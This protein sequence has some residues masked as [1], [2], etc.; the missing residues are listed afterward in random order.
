MLDMPKKHLDKFPVIK[1]NIEQA[2]QFNKDNIK[3]F[4]EFMRFIFDTSLTDEDVA[5]LV[6]R[7]MPAI[8]F[9]IVESVIS[10]LRGE[11]LT[12]QPSVEVRAAD[13]VP[14]AQLND[15]LIQKIDFVEAHLR[16]I[17]SDAS[18]DMFGNAIYTDL[19]GGGFSA[20]I[21]G[22]K[23]IHKKSFEQTIYVRRCFDP[24]LCGFDPLARESHKGDGGFVFEIFPM[25]EQQ[26]I[27]TFGKDKIEGMSFI[28]QN[29]LDSFDW[30]YTNGVEK[31]ALIC[32]YYEKQEKAATLYELSDGQTFYKKEY[33][34]FMEDWHSQVR[35]EQAPVIV[36]TRQTTI[37]KIV[38]YRV[39]ETGIL[40]EDITDYEYLPIVFF[41]GNTVNINKNGIRKK[42][43]RPYVYHAKG[44]QK[45]KNL[46]GQ[47]MGN[48]LENT[49]Q[50]KII[51]AVESI[52][53]SQLA[54][55]KNM[56]KADTFLYNHF[57]Q[58]NNFDVTLPPPREV[59]RTQ[60]PPQIAETFAMA[61]TAIQVILGNHDPAGSVSSGALSGVAYA[62]GAI[63][64][65]TAAK[66]FEAGYMAGL[67][68]IGQI[69]LDLLPKYCK[70]PRSLPV[71]NSNGERAYKVVNDENSLKLDYDPASLQIKIEA[72]VNFAIQKEMALQT[73]VSLSQSMKGFGQF[74]EEVGLQ[75][76]LDNIDI[77]GIDG[78]KEKAEKYEQQQA[79][80]K[81]QGM[82]VQQQQM[83]MQ[84]QKQ[85]MEMAL[86]QKQLQAPTS[87][88]I[89]VM[90]LQEQSKV[91]AANL[92]VKERDS[93]TKFIETMSKIRNADT[94]S[95]LKKAEIDAENTRTAVESMLNVSKHLNEVKNAEKQSESQN[96]KTS[97]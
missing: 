64:S 77:R 1:R 14:L 48:E 96:T 9:N 97:T 5:A 33:E 31:V 22:T 13:G 37:P 85:A 57:A 91:D 65:N 63:Q 43:T 3:R 93:E 75:P 36:K 7:G 49:I 18:T 87:E 71:L 19:L 50:H 86:M 61:D 90:A 2:Y 53:K 38:R 92:E 74:F 4:E 39:C 30:S 10:K 73:V 54:A 46:A 24:T 21:V 23:Y 20:A 76:L 17:I 80:M 56:Q 58:P 94:Q 29:A 78:L 45:L 35:I 82:Q 47:S 40:K 55:Y 62:R 25:T 27:D 41:Q 32:D 88:Q 79:V 42:M 81:Q 11:W 16:A 52:P 60:I 28:R 67:N 66:P 70:T 15:D 83:Q 8:E 95:E 12:Q 72:G 59:A 51:A 44:I 89:A 84:T 69:Y 34:K 68:R 6:E 26:V